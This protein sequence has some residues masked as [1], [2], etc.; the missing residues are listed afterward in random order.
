MSFHEQNMLFLVKLNPE[1][2]KQLFSIDIVFVSFEGKGYY[3]VV[4]VGFDS[5]SILVPRT[6]RLKMLL[7]KR[8]GGSGDENTANRV[9][10]AQPPHGMNQKRTR[11]FSEA[12][13]L[14]GTAISGPYIQLS[15]VA[16]WLSVWTLSCHC[17]VK[18]SP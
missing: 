4:S 17:S 11:P 14:Q 1:K 12:L 15:T 5:H 10:R 6:T 9:L 7:T 13:P 8:N 2:A 18:L 3:C 16:I